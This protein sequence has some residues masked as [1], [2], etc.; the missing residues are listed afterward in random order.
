MA[1]TR[2]ALASAAG[3]TLV[4][5]IAYG[6]CRSEHADQRVSVAGHV[7]GCKTLNVA[8]AVGDS[9]FFGGF[10][11]AAAPGAFWKKH[12][13]HPLKKARRFPSRG[14]PARQVGSLNFLVGCGGS[15]PPPESRPLKKLSTSVAIRLNNISIIAD[16]LSQSAGK[17]SPCTPAW[18][19][20]L[21]SSLRVG[22]RTT[23][24]SP[25]FWKNHSASSRVNNELV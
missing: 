4:N 2:A 13:R 14:K 24:L 11:L 6:D 21:G 16:L 17:T 1:A 22:L 10:R 20:G 23:L 9:V 7:T 18:A 3:N 19:R 8:I 12:G 5:E 25:R 15:Q